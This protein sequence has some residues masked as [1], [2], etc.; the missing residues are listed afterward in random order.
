MRETLKI[1]NLMQQHRW[2]IGKDERETFQSFHFSVIGKDVSDYKHLFYHCSKPSDAAVLHGIRLVDR[3]SVPPC[4]NASHGIHS[5]L[6]ELSYSHIFTSTTSTYPPNI[7][8]SPPSQKWTKITIRM[9]PRE[10]F[11]SSCLLWEALDMHNIIE[12]CQ[13]Y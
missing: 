4:Y 2:N 9:F 8:N 3:M 7:A 12:V 5:P 13:E 1:W 11:S 10:M 6:S